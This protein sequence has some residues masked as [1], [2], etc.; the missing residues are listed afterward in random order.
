MT[1]LYP[2]PQWKDTGAS[3]EVVDGEPALVTKL[4]VGNTSTHIT[5]DVSGNMTLE[6][7]VTGAKT[8]AELAVGSS[9]EF[10]EILLTPKESSSG[11]EGTMF[12]HSVDKCVY[13]GVDTG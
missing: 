10:D 5:K 4:E 12:Y 9:C 8:L 3:K 2:S 6:D 13:V 11:S 1:K 7:T